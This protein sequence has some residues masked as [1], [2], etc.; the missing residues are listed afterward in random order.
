MPHPQRPEQYRR[1]LRQA[2]GLTRVGDPT[3]WQ[4]KLIELY[5]SAR[6]SFVAV[7]EVD[8]ART[9]GAAR[10][11]TPNKGL[12]QLSIRGRW[13]DIFWFSFFHEASHIL[14]H[15]TT[16]LSQRKNQRLT[17]GTESRSFRTGLPH[18]P[19]PL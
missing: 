9:N 16:H 18:S 3:V 1:L 11:L 17:G 15:Q 12:I 4:P 2:R 5:A 14:S 13:A 8:G 19:R 10:W 6:I 7:P